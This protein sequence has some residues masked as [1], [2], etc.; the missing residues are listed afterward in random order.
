MYVVANWCS[1][2]IA[3]EGKRVGE[4]AGVLKK[5]DEYKFPDNIGLSNTWTPLILVFSG[6][7]V[8]NYRFENGTFIKGDTQVEYQGNRSFINDVD[9]IKDNN[10][11]ILYCEDAWGPTRNLY[12]KIA[13][14]FDLELSYIAEEPETCVYINHGNYF[15]NKYIYDTY[16]TTESV[17]SNDELIELLRKDIKNNECISLYESVFELTVS[18]IKKY[19]N[20]E[21][22]DLVEDDNPLQPIISRVQKALCTSNDRWYFINSY[23]KE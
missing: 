12:I 18:E 1:T 15:P 6:E 23:M 14:K 10:C 3:F 11:L 17:S 7:P 20:Y 13:E 5:I 22:I 2:R 19:S 9:Y 16:D 4:L 21:N 8:A